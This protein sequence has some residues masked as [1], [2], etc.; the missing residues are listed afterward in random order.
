M[1]DNGLSEQKTIIICQREEL[2]PITPKLSQQPGLFNAGPQIIG[3]KEFLEYRD[4]L[5]RVDGLLSRSG[6]EAE[7]AQRYLLRMLSQKQATAGVDAQLTKKEVRNYSDLA[8]RALRCNIVGFV[9]GMALRPLSVRL[10][11][12]QY[13][14]EFC[15]L[16]DFQKV[17]IP[18]KSQLSDFR[19]M[20]AVEE[21]QQ[22]IDR[23]LQWAGSAAN[24]LELVNPLDMTDLYVD[25]TCLMA[26]V[27]FPVD[28]LLLRDGCQ[29]ILKAILLIRAAGLKH[30]I[31]DPKELQR[32]VNQLA[33]EMTN[34]RRKKDA[35]KL[36]KKT[37]R[38][39]MKL[40]KVIEAHASRYRAVLE[41]DWE[42]SS[43]CE[44]EARQIIGRLD[45]M[46]E[47]L[48]E[49]RRQA[50]SRIIS[51][52]Q[53]PNG[54]KILSLYDSDVNVVKRGK[55]TAEVEFGNELILAEQKDGLIVDWKLYRDSAPADSSKLADCLDRIVA[56][57]I[58][59][60]AITGDRGFD[61]DANRNLLH[62]NGIFNGLCARNPQQ[63]GELMM[64][65][66]YSGRQRRR[67]QTEGRIAIVKNKFLG[68]RAASRVFTY[69]ERQTGWAILSHNLWVLARLL[70]A[71]DAAESDAA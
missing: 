23:L 65:D 13:L 6:I 64:D 43:L 14:Q 39:L 44:G 21:I 46:I 3:C 35:K 18:G 62:D 57:G 59:P 58:A 47:Q 4:F 51:Q 49:A 11:E 27:H 32:K 28:W 30:R 55:M 61:S 17:R 24:P 66:A 2:M 16:G 12:S 1:I 29:T 40:T 50:R 34:H 8:I 69:R 20:F 54:D 53:V 42:Q 63:L 22:A 33:I 41:S 25:S 60:A 48:P 36:R 38:K 10:A 45:N 37:L 68:G 9:T 19:N 56:R 67:A 26:N 31:A 52:T 15:R 70:Q 7:F 71:Q 5:E